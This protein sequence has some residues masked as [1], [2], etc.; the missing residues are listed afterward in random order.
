MTAIFEALDQQQEPELKRHRL[1]VADY[2][3]MAE[4]GVLAQDARVELIEGEI[5][6]MAPTGTR[7]YWAV[8]RLSR[9]LHRTVADRA[10]VAG[11]SS[12][13][14][15]D[16][17]EPEADLVL[18]DASTEAHDDRLPLGTDALLVIEVS[19]TSLA[20]DVK[21][22][23]TLYARYGVPEYWVID[24][25]HRKL[26]RF[27]QPKEGTW[28]NIQTIDKPGVVELPGLPGLSIDIGSVL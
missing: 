26:H 19:D 2:H 8:L 4:A 5:I 23:A 24:L 16:F 13:R 3:R 14:L 21:T 28:S 22:K 27:T 9:L 17:N 25:Q 12:L 20:Y 1:S 11:Q 15:N 18:L 7:H 10:M 6:D